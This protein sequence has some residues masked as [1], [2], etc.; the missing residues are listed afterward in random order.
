MKTKILMKIKTIFLFSFIALA[1]TVFHSCKK[2]SNKIPV[3]ASVSVNPA[4][5]NASGMVTVTVVASDSDGDELTYNY[6]VTG[7][8]VSGTGPNVTWTAPSAE[9]A[10]SVNVTV[11]DGKGGSAT[12]SA[13]LTVLPAVTQV[14]GIARFPA[15][16]SGDLV[17]SKVSL[18]TSLNNWNLNVPVKHVAVTGTGATVNF[19]IPSVNPGNYVLDVWKDNDN[20]AGWSSGDFVGWYGSGGLGSI[21]LTEFQI[22]QGQTFNCEVNMYIIAKSGWKGKLNK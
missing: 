20:D 19:T 11:S 1:V 5:V 21:S 2:E 3:I 10:H 18:Y 4:S 22:A 17:N 16:V 7:G 8:A 13:A 9:G 14:T 12:G 15:G 6:N